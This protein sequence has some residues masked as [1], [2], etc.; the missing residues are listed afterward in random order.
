M[1]YEAFINWM[2]SYYTDPKWR[3]TPNRIFAPCVPAIIREW[4]NSR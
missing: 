2:N 4:L 1:S 3:E